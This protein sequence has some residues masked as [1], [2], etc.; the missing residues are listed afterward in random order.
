MSASPT[1]YERG[2]VKAGFAAAD[3]I[4]E[5][6]FE[7]PCEIH[8]PLERHG[9]VARWDG[10]Q[11]TVWDTTQSVFIAQEALAQYFR[12][13]LNKVRVESRYMG[14]GFGSKIDPNKHTVIAAVLARRTGRPVRCF[15]SREESFLCVGNR[16][17][18]RLTLKAGAKKDGTLTALELVTLG[19]SGAYPE[20]AS[21]GFQV[22]D[23]YLCPNVRTEETNV[24]IHAG[25]ARA[26]RA[27]GL[28]A[29][30]LGP[31]AGRWTRSPTSSAWTQSRSG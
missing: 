25:K 5:M 15:L 22:T 30:L 9:S 19:T 24:F 8:T 7:T 2:D 10:D 21:N 4:V 27:P 20:D 17:P 11:L 13:P 3:A 23:L 18:N 12:L 16:P 1:R 14:G 31:R 26:F 28:P 29:V 6:T